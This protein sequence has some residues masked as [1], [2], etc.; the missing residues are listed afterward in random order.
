[1]REFLPIIST[2]ESGFRSDSFNNDETA[3]RRLARRAR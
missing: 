3:R 1:M 2:L